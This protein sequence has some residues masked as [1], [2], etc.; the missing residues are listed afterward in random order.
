MSELSNELLLK[1]C[2]DPMLF[3]PTIKSS[4]EHEVFCRGR[5]GEGEREREK[6]KK[7]EKLDKLFCY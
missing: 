1:K 3:A 2:L 4:L 7:E 6:E 5:E